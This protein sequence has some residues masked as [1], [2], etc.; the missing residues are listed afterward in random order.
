MAERLLGRDGKRARCSEVSGLGAPS[1]RGDTSLPQW[2]EDPH[3]LGATHAR[4]VALEQGVVGLAALGCPVAGR[5]L[6]MQDDLLLEPGGEADE[7]AGPARLFPDLHG[8]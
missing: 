7:V 1:T 8:A 2:T 3:Q 4:L 5:L 6:P